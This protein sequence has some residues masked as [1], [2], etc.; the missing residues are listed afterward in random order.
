[1]E[2]TLP[3]GSMQ[4]ALQAFSN[5][6][7]SIYLGLKD[8]SA[9]K[10]AKNFTIAQLAQIKGVASQLNKKIEVAINTIVEQEDLEKVVKILKV[11]ELLK[12]DAIIVQ[13]VALVPLVKKYAP[14]LKLYGSTQMA[15][16]TT[17][18]IRILKEMGFDRVVLARE[19]TLKEIKK[20]R[21]ENKD[22]ELK[23]FI[24]GA[25]CYSF[26]GLCMASYNL[27]T[28]SANKGECAQ[29]CRTWFTNQQNQDGYFFSMKDLAHTN[30]ILKLKE[31]GIDALKIEGRMKSPSYVKYAT[32]YYKKLLEENISDLHLLENLLIEFSRTTTNGWT[33]DY[34]KEKVEENRDTDS[35]V[36]T[37]H[38]SHEGLKIGKVISQNN[39]ELIIE[40][41]R[42][43]DSRDGLMVLDY[44]ENCLPKAIKFSVVNK[45]ETN[46]IIV[47]TDEKFNTPT[48]L[49]MISR[50]DSTLP[51][52]NES[53]IESYL[54][55]IN[56]KIVIY[57]DKIALNSSYLN[58]NYPITS[59]KALKKQLLKK[60][61]E[62]I[63]LNSPSSYIKIESLELVNK[64][65]YEAQQ[66]FIPLS[67]LKEIRRVYLDDIDQLIKSS[68]DEKPIFDSITKRLVSLPPRERLVTNLPFI[69][70]VMTL[71]KKESLP[72]VDGYYYLPLAPV[73]FDEAAMFAALDKI[74]TNTKNIRI[75]LNNY[76]HLKWAQQNKDVETFIDVYLYVA[77]Q[78][79]A[80]YLTSFD[81]NIIGYYPFVENQGITLPHF[82]SRSCYRYDSLGLKCEGCPRKGTYQITQRDKSYKVE[83]VNC[84]TYLLD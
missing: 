2:L 30:N 40:T 53:A 84:I 60:N 59:N 7:D 8:F 9:R 4:S 64:T 67:Q 41:N 73:T 22:I 23:V 17:S 55:P 34:G 45:K 52:I 62:D 35:L 29:I 43:V 39:R 61:F 25:L 70:P 18:G 83:V 14:S 74:V 1:M 50:H 76:A 26:S 79:S 6:A 32:L 63:F 12:I 51:L 47:S 71:K 69:D 5:G 57:D 15:I 27:T 10:G 19:L 21:D 42:D 44:Q 56:L 54:N 48:N 82:I 46:R 20:L 28:R 80:S 65:P 58:K 77:N 31:I 72:F 49:Y 13:D 24:H 81:A 36:N 11:L 38:P 37:N 33:F 68:L 78:V 3:A 66:L 16:H 75:G